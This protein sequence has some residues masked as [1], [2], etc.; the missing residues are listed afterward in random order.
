MGILEIHLLKEWKK[1]FTKKLSVKSI[2][3]GTAA[4]M[5]P[6]LC[7]AT[8]EVDESQKEKIKEIID[9]IRISK[10][11][12][13]SLEENVNEI[14][15]ISKGI[16]AHGG[17]P[18]EGLNA[19]SQMMMVLENLDL[20]SAEIKEFI[21]IYNKKIGMTYNG[22][23]MGCGFKDEISGELKLNIGV[24]KLDRDC[25]EIKL[26]VRYPI[27]IDSKIVIDNMK[28]EFSEGGIEV[29]VKND[30][31]P[32]YMDE[33][34]I[35]IQ[36]LM[37]AYKKVTGDNQAKPLVISGGTYA[38][39]MDNAVAFGVNF[40]GEKDTAHQIDEYIEIDNLL[41]CTEIFAEAI[42]ELSKS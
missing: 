41:K 26:N 2:N 4:N 11:I 38:R 12:S 8:L 29:A 17:K 10:K 18:E 14:N 33:K 20:G 3:G 42:Y 19:I 36:K 34:H 22:Q 7:T 27:T 25:L 28:K 1:N 5:V 31:K 39:A 30:M 9:K 15:I 21:N 6:E 24:I 16:S 40:P 37:K 23:S 32:I 35:L 13:I